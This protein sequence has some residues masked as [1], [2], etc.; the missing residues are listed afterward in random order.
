MMEESRTEP[1]STLSTKKKRDT[2]AHVL[3]V[4]DAYTI[5]TRTELT[6]RKTGLFTVTS[7]ASGAEALKAAVVLPPDAIVLDIVMA[8]LDGIA[9]LRELRAR[10]II[11]PVVAYTARPERYAGEFFDYGFD[12][13]IAKTETLNG[14]IATLRLLLNRRARSPG[15]T[16]ARSGST[17]ARA[18]APRVA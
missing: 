12:A 5:R 4:D 10:R 15:A 2:M 17:G 13:Y 1:C 9:T 14:L 8:G 7:V 3:V 6:L 18:R 16:D 11:C